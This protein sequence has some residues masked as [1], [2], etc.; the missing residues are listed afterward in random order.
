[1]FTSIPSVLTIS[2]SDLHFLIKNET[3][4]NGTIEVIDSSLGGE[5]IQFKVNADKG[6]VLGTLL[7]T[8]DSGEIVEFS[9]GEIIRNNDGTISINQ[10]K[11]TMPFENVTI[12]AK[13]ITDSNLKN[14][15]TRDIVLGVLVVMIIS[16]GILVALK[17]QKA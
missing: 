10:N 11:F 12:E 7:V 15:N 3:D 13:F 8:T 4:G 14:P 6:Y 16:F 17:K 5:I 1:M 2:K 9:E